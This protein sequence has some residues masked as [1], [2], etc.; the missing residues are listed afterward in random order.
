MA[1]IAVVLGNM[2][3]DKEFEVPVEAF[4]QAG[5][6]VTLVG[7]KAGS[8]VEGLY[9][10]KQTID[11]SID[12][13]KA[14][15]F[16]ALFIPGGFSPD[17]LRADQRF[18]AFTRK[19]AY[20]QKPIFAICHGPQLLINAEVLKGRRVTGYTS[21]QIDLKN[22]GAQVFD[23]EVVVDNGLVTSR[24]PDDLNAFTR[25]SLDVLANR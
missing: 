20:Q 23:E 9:G 1:N 6:K 11:L 18:V 10:G 25:A 13:A 22:A 19:F 4:K 21:I 2:Y 7:A 15:D 17:I 8:S 3:H 24:T 16:D 14:E 12:D 5:H